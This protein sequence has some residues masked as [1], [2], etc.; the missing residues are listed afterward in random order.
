VVTTEP[1]PGFAAGIG[2]RSRKQQLAWALKGAPVRKKDLRLNSLTGIAECRKVRDN[3]TALMIKAGAD[4][5][6]AMVLC[7]FA[8][9][10]LS[11]LVPALAWLKV[12]HDSTDLQLAAQFAGKLPVGFLIFVVERADTARPIFSH[13]RPLIVEDPRGL[14]LNAKAL[15]AFGREIRKSLGIAE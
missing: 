13:A 5:G 8:E 6:D 14:E 7:A 4:P 3:V 1:N 11:A 2:Q 15:E 10:D 12:Q 9:P